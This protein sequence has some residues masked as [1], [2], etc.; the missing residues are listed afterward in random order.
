MRHWR[1]FQGV[2]TALMT[3]LLLAIAC[4]PLV[5]IVL[6]TDPSRTWPLLVLFAPLAGPA[7]VAAFT[8]LSLLEVGAFW[9]A[10]RASA[11]P[12]LT[13]GA[14]ATVALLVLGVDAAWAWDRPI[15][16][17]LLPVIVV[18]MTLIAVTTILVLVA[19]AEKPGIRLR[20]AVRVSLFL[21]VRRWYLSLFS[22]FV[23]ALF[24]ALLAA[25]PALALGIAASPL[26]YIVWANSKFT[27]NPLIE[28]TL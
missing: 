10:W 11:R 13:T 12:A 15:G 9:K 8:V 23:L 28:R 1:I 5:L 2:Y 27:L 22:L 7:L 16:A 17:V 25:K 18:A 21:G 4:A 19:L 14:M 20:D 6:T 24:E 26:I 3:N